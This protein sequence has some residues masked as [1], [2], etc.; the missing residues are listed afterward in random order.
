MTEAEADQNGYTTTGTGWT[1]TIPAGGTAEAA[2]ENYRSLEGGGGDRTEITGKKVWIDGGESDPVRPGQI[3]LRL[4]RQVSGGPLEEVNAEPTWVKSG[5]TWIYTFRN[6]PEA[7]RDG[8]RYT[9]SI[10]EVVPRV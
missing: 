6:L 7:D 5:D 4:Y 8:N 1:G 2:F 10:R 9:Y 3:T